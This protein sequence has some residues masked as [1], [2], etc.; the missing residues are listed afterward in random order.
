MDIKMATA[1]IKL[2]NRNAISKSY[3]PGLLEMTLQENH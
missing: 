2:S 3:S 1:L